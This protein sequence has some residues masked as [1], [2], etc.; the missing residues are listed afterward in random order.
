MTAMAATKRG[1]QS[2]AGAFATPLEEQPR[3]E[4]CRRGCRTRSVRG[5]VGAGD[6]PGSDLPVE[7]VG[8]APHL[9]W[10]DPRP[11]RVNGL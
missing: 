10:P 2:G 1:A 3:R 7:T 6:G 8:Y 5:G 4:G 11:A 9:S